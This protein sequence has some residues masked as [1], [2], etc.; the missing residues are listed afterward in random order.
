MRLDEGENVSLTDILVA[1]HVK[2]LEGESLED[3]QVGDRVSYLLGMQQEIVESGLEIIGVEGTV[4][5]VED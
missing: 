3:P 2:Q 4:R 5:P 1:I